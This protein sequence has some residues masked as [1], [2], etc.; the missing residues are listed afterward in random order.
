M[1]ELPKCPEVTLPEGVE[2]DP[3]VNSVAGV[4]EGEEI[5]VDVTDD[6]EIPEEGQTAVWEA[7]WSCQSVAT[8]GEKSVKAEGNNL[9]ALLES[10]SFLSV[11]L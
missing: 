2:M 7:E 10:I 9:H 8:K 4:E 1:F 5:A 3:C 11:E 6:V